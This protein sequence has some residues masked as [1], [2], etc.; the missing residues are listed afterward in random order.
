MLLM[1]SACASVPSPTE[2]RAIAEK[3]AKARG[4]RAEM[5]GAGDFDLLAY[6][7]ARQT[8]SETLAIY[9]E[10]DGLAW[11]S[12]SQPSSDPTPRD[13]LALRLALAQ[14]EGN[15]VYLARPCQYLLAE[16]TGCSSF[17]WTEGRFAPEVVAATN[18]AIDALK[19]QM[20]ARRLT[21]VGYSG[22]GAVAAL[23]AARR[24][25]VELLITVA[26]NLNHRAWTNYH[27]VHPLKGSL[28]PADEAEALSRIRQWH[29]VGGRDKTIP[30]VLVED[31][32]NLFAG[33]NKPIVQIEPEFDHHCCWVEKWP[34]IWRR[35]PDHD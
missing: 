3:L 17:Y 31:F 20:G 7:P 34:M 16:S 1:L 33:R 15:A 14:P 11:L 18:A 10:G 30:P 13:P 26:G 5:L 35:M 12:P 32:A 4:W 2:R 9:I 25:D 8:E 28:N 29:W 21:L 6:L 27:R 22:G 23:V 19:L 24:G